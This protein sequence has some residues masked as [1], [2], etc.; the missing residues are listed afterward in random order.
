MRRVWEG[1]SGGRGGSEAGSR[2]EKLVYQQ[3]LIMETHRKPLRRIFHDVAQ[4]PWHTQ[5]HRHTRF[6]SLHTHPQHLCSNPTQAGPPTPTR[7]SCDTAA[8]KVRRL[9]LSQSA[10]FSFCLIPLFLN[11]IIVLVATFPLSSSTGC[12]CSGW[13]ILPASHPG[14]TSLAG[15][16]LPHVSQHM[17]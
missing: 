4:E 12:T 9:R 3:G 13:G 14:A 15:H 17:R 16:L 10:N 7:V 2:G 6:E 11:A 8:K 1:K 5:T